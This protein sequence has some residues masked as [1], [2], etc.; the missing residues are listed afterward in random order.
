MEERIVDKDDERLVRIKRTG[1][2][3]DAEDALAQES[4]EENDEV[5]F[6]IPEEEFD[7][8]LVGLTPSQLQRELERRKKEEEE[9]R[10][11]YEKLV[12]SARELLDGEK[13]AEAEPLLAEAERYV[14][15]DWRV[16]A[17]LWTARTENFTDLSP[18]YNAEY[19]QKLSE[20]DAE[21]KAFVR[22][23]AAALKEERVSLAREE[24]AIAP[25]VLEKQRERREAFA[26]NRKYY[27]VR[28]LVL[29][30]AFLLAVVGCAVSAAYIVRTQ[31]IAPVVCTAGFGG[32]AFV[33]FVAL[34]VFLRKTYLAKRLCVVNEALSSTEEGVKLEELRGKIACI[35]MVFG[36]RAGDGEDGAGEEPETPE[37]N[38]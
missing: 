9:A 3:V 1:G 35:D 25:S 8:D 20:A 33:L 22:E 12:S 11:K 19:A 7:E 23:R 27:A 36:D 16:T 13:Y 18:L 32:A 17:D 21:G 26:A 2:G 30:A 15:A 6:E 38:D 29:A 4:E 14:F 34:L 28:A 10:A 37:E 31:S 5:V 24:E